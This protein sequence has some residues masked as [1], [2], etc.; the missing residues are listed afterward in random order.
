MYRT[1]PASCRWLGEEAYDVREWKLMNCILH[2]TEFPAAELSINEASLQPAHKSSVTFYFTTYVNKPIYIFK[3]N[4]SFRG[5]LWL[6]SKLAVF[7]GKSFSFRIS[8]Q[9]VQWPRRQVT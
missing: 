8:T 3:Q 2:R 9:H 7:S 4:G 1:F 6:K 5:W